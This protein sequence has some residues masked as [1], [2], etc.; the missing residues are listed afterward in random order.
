M[1]RVL[2]LILTPIVICFLLF[3]AWVDAKNGYAVSFFFSGLG[4]I[5][6]ALSWTRWTR[7]LAPGRGA[8]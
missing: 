6:W 5:L 4:S 1:R 2:Q 7:N 8:K 3:S